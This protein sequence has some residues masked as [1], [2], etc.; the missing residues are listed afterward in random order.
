MDGVVGAGRP[1]GSFRISDEP[2]KHTG[3]ISSCFTFMIYHA[4]PTILSCILSCNKRLS[5]T[6]RVFVVRSPSA[7]S[8]ISL[9]SPAQIRPAP[10]VLYRSW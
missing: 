8:P 3:M 4:M 2:M 10:I 9:H 6:V 7:A 1:F 5:C